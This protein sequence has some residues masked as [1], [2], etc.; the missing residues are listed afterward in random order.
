MLDGGRIVSRSFTVAV[1]VNEDGKRK[2]LGVHAGHSEAEVSWTNLLR[3]LADRGLRGVRLVIADD[4]KG[5]RAA[6]RRVSAARHQRCRVHWMRNDL[7]PAPAKQRCAV[8]TMLKTIFAQESKVEVVVQWDV[9]AFARLTRPHRGH[10]PHSPPRD[11]LPTLAALMDG[12][13]DDVLAYMDFP[14]EH[15]PQIASTKPLKRVDKKIKRRSVVVGGRA[16]ALTLEQ[17]R[18]H[19]PGRRADAGDQ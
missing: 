10:A 16:M 9:V 17:R 13:R 3:S 15:W 1:G 8:A 14:G 5:L 11:K 12:S 19:P 2:V 7:V 6:A 4:H 18:D